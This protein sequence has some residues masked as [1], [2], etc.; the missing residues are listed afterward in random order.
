MWP[1]ARNTLVSSPQSVAR[2]PQSEC[3]PQPAP[4]SECGLKPTARNVTRNAI[5]GPQPAARSPQ[6]SNPQP[7]VVLLAKSLLQ[8]SCFI[9]LSST[10]PFF[11]MKKI[12]SSGRNYRLKPGYTCNQP[13]L[14][15]IIKK[16]TNKQTNKKQFL[17]IH[18]SS[19]YFCSAILDRGWDV[20]CCMQSWGDTQ[21]GDALHQLCAWY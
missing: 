17:R 6:F 14:F 20:S 21:V 4:Q 19:F 7:H 10:T 12:L 15:R 9:E 3:G 2:S 16:K 13:A 18:V 8:Q 5:C 1:A 11:Q